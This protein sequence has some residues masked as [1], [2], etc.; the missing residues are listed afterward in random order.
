MTEKK[1][2]S[3]EEVETAFDGAPKSILDRLPDTTETRSARRNLDIAKG[4]AYEVI[5]KVKRE[6]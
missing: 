5:E 1:L 4:Y 6:G 3:H 2:P